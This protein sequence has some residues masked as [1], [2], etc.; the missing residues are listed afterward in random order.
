[1]KCPQ[2]GRDAGPLEDM[3]EDEEKGTRKFRNRSH[4]ENVKIDIKL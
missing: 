4:L 3:D 1:M 2:S